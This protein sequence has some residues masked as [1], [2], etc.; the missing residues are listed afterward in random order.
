MD[1]K[2]KTLLCLVLLFGG[3]QLVDAQILNKIR[4]KAGER[5]EKTIHETSSKPEKSEPEDT[6]RT[7][8]EDTN[9]EQNC[10]GTAFYKKNFE[11]SISKIEAVEAKTDHYSP[12]DLTHFLKQA[13]GYRDKIL[14]KVPDCDVSKIDERIANA[15]KFLAINEED[16][17]P[18]AMG[19]HQTSSSYYTKVTLENLVSGSTK[20]RM[21]ILFETKDDKIFKGSLTS[22]NSGSGSSEKMEGQIQGPNGIKLLAHKKDDNLVIEF[23][24]NNDF[25]GVLIIGNEDSQALKQKVQNFEI[26]G[27]ESNG[28]YLGDIQKEQAGKIVLSKVD[29]LGHENK[30]PFTLKEFTIGD[31]LYSRSFYEQIKPPVEFLQLEGYWASRNGFSTRIVNEIYLDG[32]LAAI[33]EEGPFYKEEK[34]MVNSWTSSRKPVFELKNASLEGKFMEYVLKNNLPSKNM[35]LN[36]NDM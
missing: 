33:H 22:F 19:E 32:E 6:E 36:G 9:T 3:S 25:A 12:S 16:S 34:Q 20:S 21:D 29:N 26:P 1:K 13:K 30:G 11:S 2:I 27:S 31:K 18:F 10:A 5:T 23:Y 35:S 4:K 8:S 15:E 14:A 7:S 28:S 17:T 24:E